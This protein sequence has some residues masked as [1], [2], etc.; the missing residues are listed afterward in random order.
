MLVVKAIGH[1]HELFIPPVVARL[2]APNQENRN[3]PRIKCVQDSNWLATM[4]N[5]QFSH[6][7]VARTF[8]L[9][10]VRMTQFRT[11]FLEHFDSRGYRFLFVS[12]EAVPPLPKLVGVFDLTRHSKI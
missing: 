6:M 11:A 3:S 5:L 10:A 9:R 2:I 4:L 8:H 1:G 7:P 12:C